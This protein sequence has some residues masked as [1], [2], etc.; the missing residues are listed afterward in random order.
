MNATGI[1]ITGI[2]KTKKWIATITTSITLSSFDWE[3][4]TEDGIGVNSG[5]ST[6]VQNAKED[7]RLVSEVGRW[8]WTQEDYEV[9]L[10]DVIFG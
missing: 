1:K 6:T 7:I 5:W 3:I 9:D 10:S 8:S 2:H 4:V